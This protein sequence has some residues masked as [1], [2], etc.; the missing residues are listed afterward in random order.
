MD[1]HESD[2]RIVEE[3][4]KNL[5]EERDRC[6]ET[7]A[8]CA[9]NLTSVRGQLVQG[10]EIQRLLNS[11]IYGSGVILKN[12]SRNV[13]MLRFQ[14]GAFERAQKE[15]EKSLTNTNA[16]NKK[17][18]GGWRHCN[19]SLLISNRSAEVLVRDHKTQVR[20]LMSA[21]SF[22]ANM[23]LGSCSTLLASRRWQPWHVFAL[24]ACRKVGTLSRE[25]ARLAEDN[26]ICNGKFQ[27][28]TAGLPGT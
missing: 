15:M 2:R 1:V 14:N 17:L 12:C 4:R 10:D 28:I 9:A 6:H 26:G 13:E 22:Y 18:L 20:L 25:V 5:T 11:T 7:V 8:L 21:V 27:K 24:V 16:T 23:T 19:A 3:S